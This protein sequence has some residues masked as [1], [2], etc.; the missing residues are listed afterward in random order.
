[1]ATAVLSKRGQL[2]LKRARKDE[3]DLSQAQLAV[4]VGTTQ[5][6]ISHLEKENR[7][8]PVSIEVIRKV[9]AVLNRDGFRREQEFHLPWTPVDLISDLVPT[10]PCPS[11]PETLPS[12][13][14]VSCFQPLI[15]TV[16]SDSPAESVYCAIPPPLPEPVPPEKRSG[17]SSNIE[18]NPIR[19]ATT[20]AILSG[21]G[22]WVAAAKLAVAGQSGIDK[23]ALQLIQLVGVSLIVSYSERW[24]RLRGRSLATPW[25]V[26]FVAIYCAVNFR[27]G[28]PIG[29]GIAQC[30]NES[31]PF[32]GVHSN[33]I[34][35]FAHSALMLFFSLLLFDRTAD[36]F[37]EHFPDHPDTWQ[38][39][40][41]RQ[42]RGID[43]LCAKALD[44]VRWCWT[45][46]C[47]A[48]RMEHPFFTVSPSLCF[49]ESMCSNY[50][51]L[52]S[53][54]LIS[55]VIYRRSRATSRTAIAY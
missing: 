15:Q 53:C 45:E 47:R 33:G 35:T 39:Y 51:D 38:R 49:G 31:M 5:S 16:F 43:D 54:G 28:E 10:V 46:S 3:L 32:L 24:R 48:C 18:I 11:G 26:W 7:D 4:L 40:K 29:T 8:I 50:D 52:P 55:S 41:S 13:P 12:N 27:I 14:D 17:R 23:Y 2:E 21:Q 25:V 44:A 42:I 20:V 6:T 22:C 1:M 9:E 30:L 37:C 19:F 36:W 34:A